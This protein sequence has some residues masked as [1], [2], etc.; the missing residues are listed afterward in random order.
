MDRPD[1]VEL[2][3]ATAGNPMARPLAGADDVTLSL[4]HKFNEYTRFLYVDVKLTAQS[5]ATIENY[6]ASLGHRPQSDIQV[7]DKGR[8]RA[9]CVV[10]TFVPTPDGYRIWT[11][12]VE[13]GFDA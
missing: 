5:T 2:V 8:Q 13:F 3:D 4:T 12:T 9:S 6:A 10:A 7:H 11:R 1:T